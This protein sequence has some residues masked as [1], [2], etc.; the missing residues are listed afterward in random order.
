[1]I[2]RGGI[3][4]LTLIKKGAEANLYLEDFKDL[5]SSEKDVKVLIKERISKEYRVKRLDEMLRSSRTSLEAKLLSDAKRAG[6]P[7]PPVYRVERD[8]NFLVM[9]YIEGK[10]VKEILESL[11]P[12]DLEKL[13]RKVG[14]Q[15]AKLHEFGIIHGDLTTSNMIRSVEGEIYFI[16]FG[17]GEYNSSI[18]A[19]GT[20]I[21]LLHRALRSS[22][23]LVAEE[24]YNSVL[25]GYK[26]EMGPDSE[27]VLS[28]VRK[29]ERR[30]RYVDKEE[31]K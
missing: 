17:L 13:C 2:F 27:D 26:E 29:I 5:F 9:K 19:K 10:A 16:D 6:V 4:K 21:H 7:T 31:R 8:E 1:M 25:E 15:V 12:G 23:F 18:E 24:A 14:A 3:D 20:D 30:G 11:S 22:H 28:R